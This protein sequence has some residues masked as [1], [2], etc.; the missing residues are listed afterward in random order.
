MVL[1]N[2]QKIFVF[3]LRIGSEWNPVHD[4]SQRNLGNE[5]MFSRMKFRARFQNS[6]EWNSLYFCLNLETSTVV[7][8]G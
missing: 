5:L 7:S 1:I 3:Q 8:P 4:E 2:S 6:I